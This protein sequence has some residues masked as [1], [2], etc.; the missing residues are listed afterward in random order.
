MN[1]LTLSTFVCVKLYAYFWPIVFLL[2]PDKTPTVTVSSFSPTTI[3]IE[4]DK[5]PTEK[6]NGILTRYQ[7][8]IST[9]DQITIE[10]ITGAYN[11]YTATGKA[12]Y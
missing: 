3:D 5:I 11:S 12:L 8:F 7:V 6:S 4:W 1:C 9:G 2:V 10:D